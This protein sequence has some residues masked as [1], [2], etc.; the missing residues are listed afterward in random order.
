MS[1]NK[2]FNSEKYLNKHLDDLKHFSSDDNF[3]FDGFEFTITDACPAKNVIP[4]LMG[5]DNSDNNKGDLDITDL[6]N[7]TKVQ[8]PCFCKRSRRLQ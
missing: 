1:L 4:N 2:F 7:P 5:F 3:S 6:N 8:G